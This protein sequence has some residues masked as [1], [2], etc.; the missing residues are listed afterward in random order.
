MYGGVKFLTIGVLIA[1]YS[2]YGHVYKM[3]KSVEQGAKTVDDTETRMR[4]IPEL[5]ETKKALKG[6]KDYEKAQKD[7]SNTRNHF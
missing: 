4:R 1:F 6:Q 3:A 5:A 2:T 7:Q